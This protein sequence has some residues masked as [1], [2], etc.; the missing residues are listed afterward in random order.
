[1]PGKLIK[2]MQMTKGHIHKP[3]TERKITLERVSVKKVIPLFFS[4]T[5]YF[6]NPSLFMGK[7]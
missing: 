4:T 1:M 2:T 7:I 6:D 3:R 5:P